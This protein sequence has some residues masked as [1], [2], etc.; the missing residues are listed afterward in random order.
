M[1]LFCDRCFRYTHPWHRAP[2]IFTRIEVPR[3]QRRSM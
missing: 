2:H 3:T 1:C